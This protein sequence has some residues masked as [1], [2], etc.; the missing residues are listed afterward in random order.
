MNDRNRR[1]GNHQKEY[2]VRNT[3]KKTVKSDV[4]VLSSKL[5][6]RQTPD[7]KPCETRT[8]RTRGKTTNMGICQFWAALFELNEGLPR[9]RKMTDEEMKRQVL[10][11]FPERESLKRLGAVGEKGEL[12]VNSHRILYNGGRYTQG[13]VPEKKSVRYGLDGQPVDART[14]KAVTG[15]K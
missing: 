15:G 8:P 13:R 11:E 7:A 9:T 6:I 2:A 5:K 4:D 12:T 1:C 10:E 14:G 3:K